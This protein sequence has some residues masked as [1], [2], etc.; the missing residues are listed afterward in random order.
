MTPN[1]L[2]VFKTDI[3]SPQQGAALLAALQQRFPDLR[4]TLDLD[5][6]DRVLR[7]QRP[8]ASLV[9]WAQVQAFVQHLG[10]AIE[11]LPD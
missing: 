2:E 4:A 8:P 7:V 9:C 10:I 6:C 11:P 5:D 3:A 1:L